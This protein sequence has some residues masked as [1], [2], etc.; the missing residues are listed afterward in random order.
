MASTA[1]YT[2][3][4]LHISDLHIRGA[5]ETETWRRER[6]LD[7]AWQDNLAAFMA[8]GPID[9]VCMTGDIADWG[10]VN[11]YAAATTFFQTLLQYLKL[12]LERLFI[13]PGNH[14]INRQ[15]EAAAWSK[16]RDVFGTGTGL[17][18]SRWLSGTGGPPNGV[19]ASDLE[20][21]WQRQA[22]YRQWLTDLG[23]PQLLPAQ[24]AHG[25]L[26]YRVSLQ[27]HDRPFPI[28]IIGL[29]SA[30]LAGDDHDA[31]K[32][33]LT[34][35]QIM[36]HATDANGKPLTGLRLALIHHPLWDLADH[37]R[38]SNLLADTTDLLLRG[39]LHSATVQ[40]INDP[41]R[42]LVQ[43]AA[44]CLYEGDGADC[45]PNGC[46]LIT[47]K[48]DAQ[49]R[50]QHGEVYYRSWSPQG[51]WHADDSRYRQSHQGRVT[52]SFPAPTYPYNHSNNP[53]DYHHPAIPPNFVGRISL[54]R[55][56]SDALEKGASVSLIGDRRIG[57]SSVLQ[58]FAQQAHRQ[59]RSVKLLTGEGPEA[60]SLANFI[61]HITGQTGVEDA[62]RAADQLAVWAKRVGQ[63]GLAPLLLLDEAEIFL[64]QFD[65]RFF[66]R[67]RGLLD[68]VC[69]VVAT[70][71]PI[72]LI[73]S[74]LPNGSPF[75]NKLTIEYLGLLEAEAAEQLVQR[76][77]GLL[78]A[79]AQTLLR[80]WAGRHPYY[81]QL[82]GQRLVAAQQAGEPYTNALDAAQQ[83]AAARLR[84]LWKTLSTKELAALQQIN[85]GQVN[86]NSS[87]R[88]RG[89]VDEQG[90]LFGD[91]LANWLAE[92]D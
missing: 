54:L 47:L 88:L 16:V 84:Q 14:D 28:H 30:W 64:R 44:G 49:G 65:Y 36:R 58:T 86:A 77:N 25:K 33:W 10:Q 85:T 3:R 73:Y 75:D 11:E 40:A 17:S 50:P 9:L 69:L 72:D 5:R 37:A 87:L 18:L 51:H 70:H 8:D 63:P 4:I 46:Q 91:V 19:D 2:L 21:V 68:H 7:K 39:H 74:Q 79:E 67:L 55:K 42:N 62:D 83:E 56:L 27:R 20:G 57:K 15:I 59:G 43:L 76:S 24:H 52:W 22:A 71:Q 60:S 45:Y 13:V 48:L 38:A 34:D 23:R 41:D 32:L 92:Q 89:L 66:E 82:L 81:L 35:D 78:T 29:D 6:V 61:S 90:Q 26:G 53:Y 1:V 31:Q 12:P 80:T